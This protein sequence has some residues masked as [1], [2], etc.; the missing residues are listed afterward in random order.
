MKGQLAETRA[1]SSQLGLDL[2]LKEKE[3]TELKVRLSMSEDK[4][5]ESD[6]IAKQHRQNDE[7]FEV[8]TANGMEM[9]MDCI[10]AIIIGQYLGKTYNST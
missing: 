1:Y 8:P 3:L 4:K 7:E 9:K 10:Q 6:R 5:A 2:Q